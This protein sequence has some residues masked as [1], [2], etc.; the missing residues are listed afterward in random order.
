MRRRKQKVLSLFKSHF[1]PEDPCEQ[2][3]D[4]EHLSVSF[5]DPNKGNGM[6]RRV[7]IPGALTAVA[8]GYLRLCLMLV[9]SHLRRS[10]RREG[11]CLLW[12]TA[13][14]GLPCGQWSACHKRLWSKTI[15][16]QILVFVSFESKFWEA[17]GTCCAS[18]LG[19]L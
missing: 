9:F 16:E 4:T 10:S 1:V 11:W 2:N 6:E 3:A 13:S 12:T 18:L 17:V 19:L 14:S 7:C 8:I 15:L 5:H